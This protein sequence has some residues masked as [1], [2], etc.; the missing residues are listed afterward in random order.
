MNAVPVHLDNVFGGLADCH[1]LLR[2]EGD[3]LVLEYQSQDPLLGV[4]K[5]SV[6]QVRIPRDRLAS[7]TLSTGWLGVQATLTIQVTEMAV[8]AE[9]S[10]MSQGRLELRVDRSDRATAQKFVDDLGLSGT[11]PAKPAYFDT[12]LE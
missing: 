11:A 5:S 4:I 2:D 8:L 9:V 6:K 3:H 12:G 1:G 7:V 10:G